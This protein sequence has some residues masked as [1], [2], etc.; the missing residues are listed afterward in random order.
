MIG[1]AILRTVEAKWR[2]V[3]VLIFNKISLSDQSMKMRMYCN[4]NTN[5]F[6][7]SLSILQLLWKKVKKINAFNINKYEVWG[8]R[9]WTMYLQFVL[10]YL[11][12]FIE[13]FINWIWA[14]DKDNW[15]TR[16]RNIKSALVWYWIS[17]I[18]DCNSG[19]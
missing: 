17:S 3:L 15:Y 1:K 11:W 7:I 8:S 14:V 10:Q 5:L 9:T 12:I 18:T 2:A 19:L 6:S 13:L 16:D 4:L